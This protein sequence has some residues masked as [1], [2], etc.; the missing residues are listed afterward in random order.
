MAIA[1]VVLPLY[2]CGAL[3]C[4]RPSE[5]APTSDASAA[6][7]PATGRAALE[8]LTLEAPPGSTTTGGVGG[9]LAFTGSQKLRSGTVSYE[10]AFT[11]S[12]QA[13]D[14]NDSNVIRDDLMRS[15]TE[16]YA[17]TIR[18]STGASGIQ[19]SDLQPPKST[20]QPVAGTRGHAWQIDSVATFNGERLPWRAFS[21]TTVYRDRVYV[22]TAAAALSN[23]GEL[24]P[25]ADR[26]FAS[27]RFDGCK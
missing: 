24:R 9:G 13:A 19:P 3:A 4:S 5:P 16:Q 10:P 1:A 20:P 2:F 22:V 8:C 26:F 23:V 21:M 17:Q 18:G 25:L 11:V 27:M 12:T 7:N 15:F 6:A 14:G